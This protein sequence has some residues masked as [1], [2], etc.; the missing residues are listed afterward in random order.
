[1]EQF[2]RSEARQAECCSAEEVAGIVR[3]SGIS[4]AKI[5][6]YALMPESTEP[7]FISIF[8]GPPEIVS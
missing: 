4:G 1:M 3:C 7:P 5:N 2:T 8:F 6:L